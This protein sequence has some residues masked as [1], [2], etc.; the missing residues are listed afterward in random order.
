[1][2]VQEFKITCPGIKW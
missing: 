2:N 1:M